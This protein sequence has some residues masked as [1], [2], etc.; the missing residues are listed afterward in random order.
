MK[1]HTIQTCGDRRYLLFLA[2]KNT[3]GEQFLICP[4]TTEVVAAAFHPNGE[5]LGWQV[6]DLSAEFEK[7]NSA[8]DAKERHKFGGSNGGRRC[9]QLL[10]DTAYTWADE[11]GVVECPIQVQEFEIPRWQIA[12][13]G[14][15]AY[16]AE[17]K[18]S[19]EYGLDDELEQELTSWETNRM[20]KLWVGRDY[21][22]FPD[23]TVEST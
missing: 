22:M 23:G 2:G 6:R 20:F 9:D 4:L 5:P 13:G 17:Y 14:Y 8:P 7:I 16:L 10:Y 12:V 15:P 21:D 19:R 11:L 3:V 1:T 18:D